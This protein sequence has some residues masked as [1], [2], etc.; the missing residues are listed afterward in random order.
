MWWQTELLATIELAY[1]E[2]ARAFHPKCLGK[3]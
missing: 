3:C 1:I 2:L